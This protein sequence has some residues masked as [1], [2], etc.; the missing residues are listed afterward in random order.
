MSEYCDTDLALK[1]LNNAVARH[2]PPRGLI[3]HTDRGSTYT[4]RRYRKRLDALGFVTS[5]SRRGNCWDNAVAESTI[6]TIKQELL[7]NFTP[8]DIQAL[9]TA[10]FPYVEGFYNCQ[11]LHSSI[12]YLTPQQ[13]E[14]LANEEAALA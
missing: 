10:L 7:E 3:H 8:T 2:R 14:N 6:G 4:A 9:S 12:G 11:R 13:R 5:M 1:A